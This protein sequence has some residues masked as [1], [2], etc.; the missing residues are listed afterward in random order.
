MLGFTIKEG[1]F[2]GI[3]GEQPTADVYVGEKPVA[4]FYFPL[5][6]LRARLFCLTHFWRKASLP[7]L[8]RKA[9]E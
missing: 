8:S 7:D 6:G 1:T 2:D 5:A 4:E 3:A 9:G